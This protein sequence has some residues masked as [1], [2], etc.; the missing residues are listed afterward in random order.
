M[1]KR[2]LL[3]GALVAAFTLTRSAGAQQAAPFSPTVTQS[4]ESRRERGERVLKELT[5]SDQLP[6][7]FVELRREFPTLAGLTLN[8]ALGDVWG[9]TVLEPRTRQLVSLAG[10]AAQ[11]T[12]PQFKVHAQYALNLGVTPQELMEVIYLTTVTAGS[13]RA[14]IAAGTL[15]EL[16][17]EN[18][19]ALPLAEAK[20]ATAAPRTTSDA[21]ATRVT[22]ATGE[23]P[24]SGNQPR[25]PQSL[26]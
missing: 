10:F 26:R 21:P 20:A 18:N 23:S 22:T 17:I 19:I 4:D 11:G 12:M 5:V 2:S 15:K 9:R 1:K 16:F 3:M 8:Y 14:L 7:H 25:P 6:A 24:R 13:P